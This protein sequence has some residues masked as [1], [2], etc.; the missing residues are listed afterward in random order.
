MLRRVPS[1]GAVSAKGGEVYNQGDFVE[2]YSN[3]HQNWLPA[4]VIEVDSEG[5]I[6][7]DLKPNTKIPKEEQARRVR[8]RLRGVTP[9]SPLQARSREASPGRIASKELQRPR[10]TPPLRPPGIPRIGADSPM[11]RG[12]RIIVAH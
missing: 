11:R 10:G 2:F 8:P 12:G 5:R 4:T 9:P 6:I 7:I 3:S 1:A